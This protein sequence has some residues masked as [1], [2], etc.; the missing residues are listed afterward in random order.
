MNATEVPTEPIADDEYLVVSAIVVGADAKPIAGTAPTGTVTG[1][2]AAVAESDRVATAGTVTSAVETS[3]VVAVAAVVHDVHDSDTVAE[4][5]IAS[6][7]VCRVRDRCTGG[8]RTEMWPRSLRD[9]RST[10][11]K[12]PGPANRCRREYPCSRALRGIADA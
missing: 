1:T 11:P 2:I 12:T 6:S 5:E 9:P 4:A 8:P 7:V 10:G 3:P